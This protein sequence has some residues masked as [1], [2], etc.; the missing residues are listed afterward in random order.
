MDK[1]VKKIKEQV[2]KKLKKI[3]MKQGEV[4]NLIEEIENKVE[5]MNGEKKIKTDY[6]TSCVHLVGNKEEI[7]TEL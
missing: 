7:L 2:L 3:K 1:K 4:D 5:E 6:G